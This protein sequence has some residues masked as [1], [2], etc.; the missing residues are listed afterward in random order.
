MKAVFASL[1]ERCYKSFTCNLDLY[2]LTQSY[3]FWTF[4]LFVFS[5][6]PTDLYEA[7]SIL[8]PPP[9]LPVYN[10]MKGHGPLRSNASLL[11]AFVYS[12]WKL[13]FRLFE[14]MTRH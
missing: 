11:S 3:N 9:L 13:A 6:D 8:P 1:G 5:S 12:E 4:G 2:Q 14:A 10:P 7:V